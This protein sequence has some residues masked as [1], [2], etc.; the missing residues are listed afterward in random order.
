MIGAVLLCAVQG[1]FTFVEYEIPGLHVGDT[2][3]LTGTAMVNFRHVDADGDGAMDLLFPGRVVFQRDGAYPANLSTPAPRAADR[4][5]CDVHEGVL[6]LRLPGA[7]EAY[8]LVQNAWAT[9][10]SQPITWP[11]LTE[12]P[13]TDA[14]PPGLRLS[15]FLYPLN[16]PG[17]L[18]VIVPFRDGVHVF[19]ERNGT[20]GPAGVWDVFPPP[21]VASREPMALWPAETRRIEFP[22]ARMGCY[23]TLEGTALRVI[24]RQDLYSG[25]VRFRTRLYGI[26][27]GEAGEFLPVP[28]EVRETKP[29]PNFLEPVRL[30]ADS[31]LDFAGGRWE[32]S[33]STLLPTPIFETVATLDGGESIFSV[34]TQAYRPRSSFV[35]FD[36]DGRLDMVVES[37]AALEGGI[38]ETLTR[39]LTRK[40]LE[41]EIR[42]YRQA[43]GRFVGAPVLQR[44]VTIRFSRAPFRNDPFFQ[45]YQAGELVD[46]TGDFNGDGRRDLVVQGSEDRIDVFLNYGGT[47]SG[48]PAHSLS[49]PHGSRFGIV[50]VDADGRSDIVVHWREEGVTDETE[51]GRVY[52]SRDV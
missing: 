10:F 4:P 44:R 17:A 5:Y 42:V 49:V 22:P 50:D 20:F 7:F 23:V 19:R 28:I 34:R 3:S 48:T 27:P 37:T 52:F 8:R 13:D 21:A 12:D 39:L 6:Y 2:R 24:T 46:L 47:F 41:H 45:R 38:R 26:Q 1:A 31:E 25:Q 15:R 32:L 30:N 14:D 36:G 40:T 11:D 29:L 51:A 35:D 16:P 18:L 33:D 9:V 43:A